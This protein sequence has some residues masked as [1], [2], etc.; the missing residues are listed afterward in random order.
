MPSQQKSSTTT[1]EPWSGAKPALQYG[2]NEATRLYQSGAPKYYPSSTVAQF[3]PFQNASL[4]ATGARSLYGNSGMNLGQGQI[5]NILSGDL[6]LDAVFENV[7]GKVLPA[8]MSAYS[9]AGRTPGGAG[10][11]GGYAAEQ[12]TNAYA[13]VAMQQMQNALSMAPQYAQED[14]NR[15]DRLGAAGQQ[16]QTQNQANIQDSV[17]RYNY[18]A[19]APWDQLQRLLSSVQGAGAGYGSS[20]QPYYSNPFLGGVSGLSGLMGGLGSLLAAPMFASSREYKTDILPLYGNGALDTV[21][22]MP[23]YSW[24]YRGDETP[25]VGPV[26]EEWQERTGL[27]DGKSINLGDAV[28]LLFGA[29]G[30]LAQRLDGEDE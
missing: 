29:V 3:T 18:A 13:P 21:K 11:Y 4:N 16:V 23:V 5:N 9:A 27:G 10:S 24:K 15:I 28:G 20:T 1:T 7:K 22:D 12:L 2:I 8:A 14:W 30:E 26:A 17:N 19:N 25:H 6:G